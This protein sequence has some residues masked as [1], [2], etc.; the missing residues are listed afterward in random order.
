M[1]KIL[2]INNIPS[3]LRICCIV[4]AIISF[5]LLTQCSDEN[6]TDPN[7]KIE[8]S[9]L[10]IEDIIMYEVNIR[11]FSNRGDF[12][13]VIDRLD[14][15][16]SLSVNTLWLMPIYPIGKIKTVNSPYCINEYTQ[17][18]SE[19]GTINDFNLL[20]EKAHKREMQV[21]IDWVA[22][23]TS[24]DHS[25]I[26]NKGWYTQNVNGNIIHPEGTNWQDVADLN[27]DNTEM[28]NEMIR[29]MKYWVLETNIDGFRCDAADF[30]PYD[31]WK[32]A[33]D[34]LSSIK[35]KELIL[36]AERC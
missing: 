28:R 6:P 32:Q 36:L 1:N 25:W 18:N 35:G 15:I 31:F 4:I 2:L 26:Q 14:S 33:L 24:W 30:V 17:V 20:V 11:A 23:H 3:F 19:F 9:I 8:S 5:S 34:T 22:N 16:K 7:N 10:S 13:G 29:A 12:Q 21:I 27:F